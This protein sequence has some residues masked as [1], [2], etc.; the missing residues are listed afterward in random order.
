MNLHWL[1]HCCAEDIGVGQRG[2]WNEPI[3][4]VV[5]GRKKRLKLTS[6]VAL[7]SQNEKSPLESI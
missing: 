1:G 5:S 4:A 3:S 7:L 2:D 6:F